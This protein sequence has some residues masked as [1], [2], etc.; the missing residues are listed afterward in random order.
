MNRFW[1]W[2]L[3]VLGI[4]VLIA[5]SFGVALFLFRGAPVRMHVGVFGHPGIFGGMMLGMGGFMLLGLFF[6]L[7]IPIG[8]LV[9]AGFGIA[10]LVRSGKKS[11]QAMTTPPAMNTCAHCGKSVAV[12]WTTCP[13]CGNKIEPP[14]Q[15]SPNA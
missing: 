6:R 9:L 15:A 3:I 12:D 5:L 2:F 7:L 11:D 14:A 10:Y 13:Y 8:I 4:L 1:K